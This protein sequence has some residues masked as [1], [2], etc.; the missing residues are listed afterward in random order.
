MSVLCRY[1]G[2]SMEARITFHVAKHGYT[3]PMIRDCFYEC[4]NCRSR[5]PLVRESPIY[6]TD[7]ELMDEA[8]LMAGSNDCSVLRV[9]EANEVLQDS[10]D[11]A[12]FVWIEE[13]E[14]CFG[15]LPKIFPGYIENNVL[16]FGNEQVDLTTPD[17]D[18]DNEMQ[19]YGIGWR[20]WT[21]KPD[22]DDMRDTPWR[23]EQE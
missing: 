23:D 15:F 17:Q 5:S 16:Y 12:R 4:P 13:R 8:A 10:D 9:L 21:D 2:D 6:E 1:C 3:K 11:N 22:D 19:R 18:P 14:P 20:C 7:D